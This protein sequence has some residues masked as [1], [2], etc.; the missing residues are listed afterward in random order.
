MPRREKWLHILQEHP[1][2]YEALEQHA[3]RKSKE[4]V[5]DE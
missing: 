3:P 1:K 4:G 2:L 5:A